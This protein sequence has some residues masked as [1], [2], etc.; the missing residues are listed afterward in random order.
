M[1]PLRIDDTPWLQEVLLDD[2]P[3]LKLACPGCGMVGYLDDDQAHGR[4]S[5]DCPNCPFH[6]TVDWWAKA[7][8]EA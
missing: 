1:S 8:E 3:T 2:V 5:T 6:E 4:V 7:R